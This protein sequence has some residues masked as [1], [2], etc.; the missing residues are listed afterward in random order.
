L[1]FFEMT[2]FKEGN[3]S[4]Y[5]HRPA[6]EGDTGLVM[7]HGAGGNAKAPF[8]VMLAEAFCNAGWFV[9]RF[10][11]AFRKGKSSGPPS[12]AT[13]VRDRDSVRDAVAAMRK[14][15]GGSVLLGG[16]SY[17]GRQSTI[18][19]SEEPGLVEVLL[20]CSYPLHPPG[21]PEQLRTAHFPD[22]R[23][24]ALFV[25]GTKDPFGSVEEMKSALPLIP[26]RTEMSIVEGAGHD[27][28]RGK[29][30][31]QGLVVE[32]LRVLAGR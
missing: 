23:T 7:T 4:G 10:D 29:F 21:K 16:H 9:L 12:P 15:C 27:L 11:L 13:A 30:D 28:K 26:A 19:L 25:H 6:R 14:I 1:Y 5:L 17:G 32:R 24:P 8:L 2:V 18:L 20:L 31:L 22:L 3:V